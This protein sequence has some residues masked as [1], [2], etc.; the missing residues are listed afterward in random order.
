MKPITIVIGEDHSLVREGIKRILEEFNDFQII[1]EASNGQSFLELIKSK[2]PEIAIVDIRMPI[3]N[4]VEVLQDLKKTGTNTRGLI[5][6]AFADDEYILDAME[7]GAAGY[8]LKS[9]EPNELA[10]AIRTVHQGES[11]LD[12][13]I[14][15]RLARIWNEKRG[16]GNKKSTG[17]EALSTREIEVLKLAIKGLR[18]KDVGIDLNISVRTV[19][20]H[21][22]SIFNKLAVSS[23][24]EAVLLGIAFWHNTSI[25]N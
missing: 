10:Q 25:E 24:I 4:G 14:S 13:Q 5:L 20:G 22:N 18:N 21:F 23:K 6:T 19:E 17:I 3:L 7:A 16:G 11:V 1:G 8:L 9:V 12:P 2:K 15:L